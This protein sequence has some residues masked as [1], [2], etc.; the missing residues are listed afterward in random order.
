MAIG[1]NDKNADLKLR[2]AMQRV[3]LVEVDDISSR[4]DKLRSFI[5]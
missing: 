4:H 3:G 5:D 2:H 1:V